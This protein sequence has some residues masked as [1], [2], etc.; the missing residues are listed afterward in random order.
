MGDHGF[1]YD[2]SIPRHSRFKIQNAVYLPDQNYSQLYDSISAVNQFRVV[3][4]TLFK[5]NLPLLN[6]STVYLMGSLH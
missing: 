2:Q 6:D 3:A 1:R 4:N 5:Q